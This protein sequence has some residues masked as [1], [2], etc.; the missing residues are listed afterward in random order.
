MAVATGS[1]P[2]A[3]TTAA[4]MPVALLSG[5]PEHLVRLLFTLFAR[6]R[7]H[8]LLRAANPGG[9]RPLQSCAD[10]AIG[11]GRRQGRYRPDDL[12]R[13]RT[14]VLR[15]RRPAAAGFAPRRGRAL[16]RQARRGLAQA[17]P[18]PDRRRSAQDA[19]PALQH[20]GRRASRRDRRR[21]A[22]DLPAEL[23]RVLRETTFRI[24]RQRARER[25]RACGPESAV[26]YRP[27]VPLDRH[28]A[29]DFPCRDLRR[30]LGPRAAVEPGGPGGRR[31]AGQPVGQ[32]HHHR[33]GRVAPAA[34]RQPVGAR[35]CG[36]RLF[37]VGPRRIDNRSGM[38]RPGRDLRMR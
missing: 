6:V 24:G 9:R 1:I 34:V 7:P 20:R 13:A 19:W 5:G 22:Q 10:A 18:G 28:R 31:A 16:D 37:G 12:P 8:R 33:Q 3:P 11:Q 38:G 29:H 32:Q 27:V 15:D 30:H 26:R 14:L 21:G 36:L 23:S 4:S 35:E 17:Q 2:V 25:D